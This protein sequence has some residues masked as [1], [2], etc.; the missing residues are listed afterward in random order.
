MF[1]LCAKKQVTVNL[2]TFQT[3][4]GHSVASQSALDV[5]Y[6]FNQDVGYFPLLTK[7]NEL[8]DAFIY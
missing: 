2:G 8:Y 4:N 7:I 5:L 3:I 6:V 1:S